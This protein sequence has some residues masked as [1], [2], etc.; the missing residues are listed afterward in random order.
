MIKIL[1]FLPIIAFAQVG[2]QVENP[3][4]TLDIDGSLRIRVLPDGD[5]G[6]DVIMVME[7]EGYLEASS[8]NN[9]NRS[10]QVNINIPEKGYDVIANS[11]FEDDQVYRKPTLDLWSDQK[12][13]GENYIKSLY[14]IGLKQRVTLPTNI[15]SPNDG[16]I[17][18]ITFVLIRNNPEEGFGEEKHGEGFN[19][20]FVLFQTKKYEME[21]STGLGCYI[22]DKT[23]MYRP[24]TSSSEL[25]VPN[26]SYAYVENTDGAIARVQMKY[27]AQVRDR[28]FV[29]Y[30]FNG[31][32]IMSVRD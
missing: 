2:I 25:F 12:L 3:T 31:K 14:F 26:P 24:N 28:A 32:W 17:R 18:K 20:W 21:A 13:Y 5:K 30:D 8:P 7:E 11:N 9:L 27:Q 23:Y 19:Q 10:N 29:F 22:S 16:K 6:Q 1:C 15:T 4:A